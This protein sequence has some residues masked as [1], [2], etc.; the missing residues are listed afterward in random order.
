MSV[1]DQPARPGMRSAWATTCAACAVEADRAQRGSPGLRSAS[2]STSVA[3]SAG[4]EQRLAAVAIVNLASRCIIEADY[5]GARELMAEATRRLEG[6]AGWSNP[7]RAPTILAPRI[8]EGDRSSH[9]RRLRKGGAD[10]SLTPREFDVLGLLVQGRTDGEIGQELYISRKTASVH[11]TNIKGKLGA[12]SRVGIVTEAI[13]KGIVTSLFETDEDA[14]R[15]PAPNGV[16]SR[17]RSSLVV[18]A[19]AGEDRTTR[20]PRTPRSEQRSSG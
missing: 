8:Q 17:R 4:A 3:Q 11:V 13:R 12:R 18:E 6:I 16:L 9:D 1:L 15:E 2:A 14:R 19:R 10:P 20:S 7:R 5:T